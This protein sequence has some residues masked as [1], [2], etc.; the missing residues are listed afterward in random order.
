MHRLKL[1]VFDIDN[2]ITT[3]ES[4]WEILHKVC[5]TWESKGKPY[6]EQYLREEI[7]FDEF[8]RRDVASW[9]DLTVI[10]MEE[11]FTQVALA[12]GFSELIDVLHQKNIATAIVSCSIGQFGEYLKNRFKI[13]YLYTNPLE[14]I[15]GRLTG[16]ISLDVPGEKKA[17][18]LAVLVKKINIAKENIAVIGDS[19]F[20]LPMFSHSQ[21][22]FI[23]KN[24]KYQDQ[25]RYFIQDFFEVIKLLEAC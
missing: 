8:A 23:I 11:A 13:D 10:K 19:H 4:I 3:G 14:I 9:K 5:G 12:P 25:A 18:I 20:D 7:D 21:H 2:T 6:L 17:D 22:T 24:A 16:K 1:F 15:N